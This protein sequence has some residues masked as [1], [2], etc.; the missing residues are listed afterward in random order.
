MGIKWTIMT[1]FEIIR[2]AFPGDHFGLS[3]QTEIKTTEKHD[4]CS[5]FV[6]NLSVKIGSD[7]RGKH[8]AKE[9]FKYKNN[10]TLL[11]LDLD[12]S[13]ICLKENQLW[14]NLFVIF[15]EQIC[16]NLCSLHHNRRKIQFQ[17]TI[18]QENRE[19]LRK[20]W[21]TWVLSAALPSLNQEGW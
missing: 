16:F 20:C 19:H 3:R 4:C 8:I 6:M 12:M 7:C 17:S 15:Y 5:S 11:T 13:P 10:N 2:F 21:H 14:T 18:W 1:V 9:T